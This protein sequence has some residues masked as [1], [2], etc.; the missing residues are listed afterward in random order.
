MMY[1]YIKSPQHTL[2]IS[3]NFICQLYLKKAEKIRNNNIVLLMS[4]RNNAHEVLN[5]G[6]DTWYLQEANNY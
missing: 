5:I 2:E 4:P 6:P 3:C 1:M